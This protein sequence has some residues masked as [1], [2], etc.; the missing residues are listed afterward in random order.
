MPNPYDELPYRSRPIEWTAPERLAVASLLHGGPRTSLARYRVLEL[1]CAN[2]ANLIPLAY[3]RR[4]AHFVGVDGAQTQLEIAEASRATLRL[5]NVELVHADFIRADEAISGEFDYIVAHGVFSWVPDDARDAL[6]ALCARRLRPGG[7]LYLN[8]N[9]YPGWSVRGVVRRFL[10]RHTEGSDD[11][12]T[13]AAATQEAAAR[14]A[15][16]FASDEHPYAQLMAR[17]LRFVCES[18]AS[19][20]AHEYLAADNRA[21]WRSEFLALA[22]GYG[23]TYVADADFAHVTG[24]IPDDLPVRVAEAGLG[25]P[26]VEDA[27]DLL[28]YRQLHSPIFTTEPFDRRPPDVAE[29]SALSMAACLAPCGTSD[30]GHPMFEHPS[31]YRVDAKS[32]AMR[33]ALDA[34]GPIWPRGLPVGTLF[35]NVC[36]AIDDLLLLHRNGL[37]ELRLVEADDSGV[38]PAPLHEVEFESGYATTPYHTLEPPREFAPTTAGMVEGSFA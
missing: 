26:S 21:Y 27:V 6:F 24:R 10:L 7:L 17:E 1:G 11:L 20:V 30:D 25:A 13:R 18:D 19:Y 22:R 4:D 34:L 16:S 15:A 5:P 35:P 23:L 8:Y 9:A 14:L 37:V 2:G 29:W 36:E 32:P 28:C 31:G 12:P 33:S 3:Y 38:D